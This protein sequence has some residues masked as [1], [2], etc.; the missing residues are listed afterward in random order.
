MS[1]TSVAMTDQAAA[2]AQHATTS[3]LHAVHRVW[4]AGLGLVA[5]AGEQTQSALRTLEEKGQQ[6]EPSVSAPFK[7]AGEAA[8]RVMG[9]AGESVKQ[10]GDVIPAV[11]TFRLGR[12]VSDTE[13]KEQIERLLDERLAPIVQRLDTLEEKIPARRKKDVE[14]RAERE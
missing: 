3:V 6:L 9:R 1:D 10:V 13:L 8:G 14:E 5:I 7:R 11:P 4:L 12:R 2:A